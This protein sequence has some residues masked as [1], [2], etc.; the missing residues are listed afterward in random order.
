MNIQKNK[1]LLI[2]GLSGSGKTHLALELSKDI[3]LTKIDSSML[4]SIKNK[5]YKSIL[6]QIIASICGGIL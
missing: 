4:K 3:I 2:H 6:Q 1:P 5:D